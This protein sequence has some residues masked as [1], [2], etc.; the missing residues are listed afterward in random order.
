MINNNYNKISPQ[1][2]S[3][4]IPPQDIEI[5][6]AVLGACF[7]NKDAVVIAISILKHDDFYKEQHS[8]IFQSIEVLSSEG[9]NVDMLSV[10]NKLRVSKNLESVGGAYYLSTLTDVG[11]W[12][13]VEYNSKVIKELSTKRKLIQMGC[14]MADM[15]FDESVDVDTMIDKVSTG[16]D[17]IQLNNDNTSKPIL[18]VTNESMK[19]L[20][21]RVVS[22]KNGETT[23][24]PTPIRKINKWTNGWQPN[25][26]IIIA[27][28]PSMGKTA[29]S[30][31]FSRFAA[32]QNN[33]G[34]YF[35]LEMSSSR[36]T[37][38]MIC[39]YS[40]V[41][42]ERYRNGNINNE[43]WKLIENG[44]S[45][46]SQLPIIIDDNPEM[47]LAYI[48]SWAN[49]YHRKKLCNWI[50]I[51][52]LQLITSPFLKGRNREQ[53]V[54]IISKGLKKIAKKLHVPLIALSQLNRDSENRP[55]KRPSLG[56]LRESGSLEQDADL[57]IFL[58]RPAKYDIM[59]DDFGTTANR[60]DFI[61]AKQ[62]DGRIGTIHMWH[63]DSLTDFKDW[64]AKEFD[65]IVK[66]NAPPIDSRIEPN[67]DF[68][69]EVPF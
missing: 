57:V 1:D 7:L 68:N 50:M 9:N 22:F 69:N 43:D 32:E 39:G 27:A 42:Y 49:Y 40:G 3:G 30:L 64:D 51:D 35:S 21:Q 66:K 28:R 29:I 61:I 33:P 52:Y 16:V 55:D 25:D 23:G 53:E 13:N 5:E 8:L 36:I 60:L 24:I 45:H 58:H 47:T 54:A 26:F 62:R 41:D 14:E 18:S 15:G 10:S 63:N 31:F 48:N 19:A 67:V 2:N 12:S 65:D 44:V 11:G 46:I 17:A 20:E 38:R 4:K 37:D 34:I 59:E 56:S 6:K